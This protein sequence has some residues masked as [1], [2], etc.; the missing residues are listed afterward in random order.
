MAAS[1]RIRLIIKQIH[2]LKLKYKKQKSQ[3]CNKKRMLIV[4]LYQRNHLQNRR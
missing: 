4:I 2:E 3:R 1:A